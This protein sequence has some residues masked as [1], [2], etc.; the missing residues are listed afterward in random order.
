MTDRASASTTRS[1]KKPT[2]PGGYFRSVLPVENLRSRASAGRM[3]DGFQRVG[4]S[5]PPRRST[6]E[7]AILTRPGVAPSSRPARDHMVH[8]MFAEFDQTSVAVAFFGFLTVVASGVL[9]IRLRRLE[10]RAAESAR[11]ARASQEIAT[12]AAES[13]KKP[14]RRKKRP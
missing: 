11:L 12:L 1:T 14:K 10:L 4:P 6:A 9:T 3:F 7:S 2:R 5:L 13:A 8:S